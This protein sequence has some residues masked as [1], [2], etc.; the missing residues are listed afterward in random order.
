MDS[1]QPAFENISVAQVIMTKAQAAAPDAEAFEKEH[2][3]FT[4]DIM[5]RLADLDVQ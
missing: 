3:S 5:E 4:A 2:W 1:F